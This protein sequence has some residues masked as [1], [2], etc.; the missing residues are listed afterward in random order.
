MIDFTTS[1]PLS[2]AVENISTRTPVGSKLTSAQWAM[3]PPE[4]RMRSFFS[5]R[6]EEER[7]LVSMQ[8][9]LTQ[10]VLLARENGTLMDRSRFIAEMQDD[11]KQFGY[12]PDPRKRGSIQDLSSAGRLGLIWDMNLAQAEG[13]AAWKMGMDP[14]M[15]DAAPAQELI[16]VAARVDK[17]PWPAI[18]RENGGQF[19]GDPLPDFPDAPGRMIAIKTDPIWAA[20]SEFETPWP[21]F[22]W[23]S[24]IGLRNVRRKEA[25]QLGVI[26]KNAKVKPLDKPFNGIAKASLKGIPEANRKAIIEDL[27]GEVEIEGDTIRLLPPD[28]YEQ[29]PGGKKAKANPAPPQEVNEVEQPAPDGNYPLSDFLQVNLM[30]RVAKA[31]IAAEVTRS[32]KLVETVHSVPSMPETTV[33]IQ[34]ISGGTAGQLLI[35]EKRRLMQINPEAFNVTYATFH[36]I[37]H[38]LDR[39]ALQGPGPR[40][41]ASWGQPSLRN[42]M[43]EI[44]RSA[45]YQNLMQR[46]QADGQDYWVR[47]QE[48]FARAYAQFIAI[49]SDDQ[50]ALGYIRDVRLRQYESNEIWK[51]SQWTQMD[52]SPIR[53]ALKKLFKPSMPT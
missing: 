26:P 2:E 21:P 47:R 36:E 12:E 23:G 14:D 46:Y 18:W 27:L 30:G 45:A 19:Y 1:Q 41:Y 24:G 40:R 5:A 42:V 16:R 48:A 38:L 28:L 6:V 9:K 15:L 49:E 39:L 35:N 43:R 7:Y 50:S 25:E 33:Q 37:G 17:R 44:F 32:I 51:D 3:V 11:L 20:I 34:R 4:I 22:R 8:D 53:K 13:Y 29:K 31:K 10:R 52:F